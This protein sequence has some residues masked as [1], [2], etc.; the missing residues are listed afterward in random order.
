MPQDVRIQAR[1]ISIFSILTALSS[2]DRRSFLDFQNAVREFDS[3][4][5]YLEVG[6]HLGGS[7][8]A[9]LIDSRCRTAISIDNRT[10]SSPD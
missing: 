5:T 4:Y 2:A 7:L 1:D 3:Q 6:S 9:P 8:I 10:S